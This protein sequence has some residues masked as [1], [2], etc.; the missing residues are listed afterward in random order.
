MKNAS[1]TSSSDCCFWPVSHENQPMG[2]GQLIGGIAAAQG[3]GRTLQAVQR[4]IA[5]RS[6]CIE[7]NGVD[8]KKY[9][10]IL[11]TK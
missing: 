3:G 8:K 9:H 11:K 6:P 10:Y 7:L 1:Q 2:K 4:S 5:V